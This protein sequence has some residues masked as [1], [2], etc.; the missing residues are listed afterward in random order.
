M[1]IQRAAFVFFFFSMMLIS[2]S[3]SADKQIPEIEFLYPK[4]GA[5]ITSDSIYFEV[6]I[7]DDKKLERIRLSLLNEEGVSVVNPLF[8]HAMAIDTI[9]RHAFY[10]DNSLNNSILTLHVQVEDGINQKNK[11]LKFNYFPPTD[12][13]T[14]VLLLEH[15]NDNSAI[16]KLD[17]MSD[18]IHRKVYLQREVLAI[19]AITTTDKMY[20]MTAKP[21]E[22]IALDLNDF[23]QAWTYPSLYPE[24]I[25]TAL[26]VR[27]N[28]VIISDRAGLIRVLQGMTGNVVVSTPTQPDTITHFLCQSEN[29]IIAGQE[30]VSEGKYFIGM[31]YNASGLMYRRDFLDGPLIGYAELEHQNASILVVEKENGF[32]IKRFDFL[33]QLYQAVFTSE[34]FQPTTI[35]FIGN[36]ILLLASKNKIYRYYLG[37]NELELIFENSESFVLNYDKKNKLI[38][39]AFEHELLRLDMNG[40][41][42]KQFPVEISILDFIIVHRNS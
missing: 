6:Q 9:I 36:D 38:Y 27:D 33:S 29:Y 13:I 11:Y 22:I 2:C 25:F 42:L 4:D 10:P 20:L 35:E 39:I 34:A 30:T 24:K 26:A 21:S 28:N 31:Y 40:A 1:Q 19:R 41:I 16:W 7:R 17:L 3:K 12:F 32:L 15:L 37:S 5:T 14:E 18:K 8:I 23:G